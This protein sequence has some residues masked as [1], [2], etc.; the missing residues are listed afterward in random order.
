MSKKVL[1][2]ALIP[3]AR[4]NWRQ[5]GVLLKPQV[6]GFQRPDGATQSRK[7]RFGLVQHQQFSTTRTTGYGISTAAKLKSPALP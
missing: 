1:N 5:I 4:E 3:I 2:D 7:L 6:C